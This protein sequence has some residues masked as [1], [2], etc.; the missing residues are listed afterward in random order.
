VKAEFRCGL[1]EHPNNPPEYSGKIY[2]ESDMYKHLPASA[3]YLRH[4]ENVV[5][6]SCET[7][8][9]EEDIRKKIVEV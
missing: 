2:P 1:T 5:F 8:V 6:E 9:A 3:Y 4:T 7:I